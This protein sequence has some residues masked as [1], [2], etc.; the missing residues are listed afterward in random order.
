MELQDK[1]KK[2]IEYLKNNNFEISYSEK[3]R[4]LVIEKESMFIH[5]LKNMLMVGIEDDTES[6][7]IYEKEFINSYS[8]IEEDEDILGV[9]CF[10]RQVKIDLEDE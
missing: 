9:N 6:F 5:G 7:N 4:V 8:F 3:D 10:R 1:I 2:D